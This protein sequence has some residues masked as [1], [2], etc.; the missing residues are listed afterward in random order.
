MGKSTVLRGFAETAGGSVIDLDDVE[1]REAIQGNLAASVRAG[2]PIC[3]DEYQR[4]PDILDALKARLNR[5]GSPPGTAIITGSTRQDAL[6][7]TAQALT[8]RLHSLVIWPLSQGEL[9]GVRE[10]LLEALAGDADGVVSAVP[11][12]STTRP[13]YVDRV[14]YG[15]MPLAPASVS[16][17]QSPLVR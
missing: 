5:E 12:S 8:G 15:G 7:A 9:E 14:C 2:A 3:I 10:N 1:V 17:G 11:S 16:L 6:P 4:V 13:D